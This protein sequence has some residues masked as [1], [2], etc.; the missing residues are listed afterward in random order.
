M[1][2]TVNASQLR[3][4][5]SVQIAVGIGI[6]VFWA[7]FYT[8]GMA[9]AAPPPCYFAF[10]HAFLPPDLILAI[11]LI[12]SGMNVLQ[13]GTWGRPVALVSAGGLLFLGVIDLTF[14]IQNGMYSGALADGLQA[15][16]IPAVCIAV[17]VWI[18]LVHGRALAGRPIDRP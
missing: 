12:A 8:V 7:L 5:S 2:Q 13:N 16:A 1:E 11:A 3:A 6:L 9:P 10:E 14:N 18:F 17:G 4:L 15:A